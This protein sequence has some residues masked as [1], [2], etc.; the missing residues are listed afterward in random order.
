VVDEDVEAGDPEIACG[1]VFH[2]QLVDPLLGHQLELNRSY[3]FDVLDL[4]DGDR[5]LDLFQCLI[6]VVPQPLLQNQEVPS[7][8]Y[9]QEP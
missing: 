7:L 3:Q 4:E 5:L 6:G 8:P 2:P 1:L 9:G